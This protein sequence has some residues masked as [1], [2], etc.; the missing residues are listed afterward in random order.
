MTLKFPC[1][2]IKTYLGNIAYSPPLFSDNITEYFSEN[3]ITQ[4]DIGELFHRDFQS[5]PLK[6]LYKRSE[7]QNLLLSIRTMDNIMVIL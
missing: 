4:L 5:V 7:K 2:I 3:F 6:S 1:P